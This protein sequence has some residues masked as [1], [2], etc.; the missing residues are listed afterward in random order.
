[1]CI[2][3]VH[4]SDIHFGQARGGMVY[5]HDD[6][7]E[8]LIEDVK[9]VV[10]SLPAKRAAGLLVTGDVAYAGKES[11]YAIAAA[12]L[13]RVA[14]AAGCAIT[15]VQVIPGNH[16]IDMAEISTLTEIMLRE[17]ALNGQPML[18]K[19][20][21]N[22]ID[23]AVLYRRF[24][25]FRPFADAYRCPLSVEGGL[26]EERVVQLAE[27]RSIRFIRL[28]SALI[29]SKNDEEGKLI[30]GERQR[31]L[32][33]RTGEELIVLS[34]HPLNWL[35]DS[36]DAR[37]FI[38]SRARVFISGHEHNPSVK[39]EKVEA[40]S[41]LMLLAAGATVPPRSGD[42]YTYTYNVLEF[43]WVEAQD[44]LS[45]RVYPRAWV[46]ETKRFDADE[47]GLGG[48]APSF[49]LACPNFREARRPSSPLIEI[50]DSRDSSAETIII[51]TPSEL[52]VPEPAMA[53]SYPLL[54]LRFFRDISA[55]QRLKIF[56]ELGAL[57]EGWSDLL[58]HPNERLVLDAL[59][60]DG[61]G[62]ELTA[63]LEEILRH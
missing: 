31:V 7:K 61:R 24:V 14:K 57:P 50:A 46:E 59:I 47:G 18:D 34:H 49:I 25:A 9:A 37:R 41:D 29:C 30:L 58:S 27:N 36:E 42:G 33:K 15:D 53:A 51:H 43:S 4:L 56:V 38:R 35:Q 22:D 26:A 12:W 19:F 63:A 11:E 13:D 6:V 45:V 44:A 54:V 16:D 55:S 39:I 1:M 10:A 48:E 40:G 28:N 62:D 5:V 17:V 21:G 32:P 23:R 60:E 52:N 2:G 3:F 8:R 20:L